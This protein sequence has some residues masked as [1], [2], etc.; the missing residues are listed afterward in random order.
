MKTTRGQVVFSLELITIPIL[1]LATVEFPNKIQVS[2]EPWEL[3]GQPRK[4][5][6]LFYT[7]ISGSPAAVVH[8]RFGT[9]AQSCGVTEQSFSHDFFFL[10]LPLVTGR[11]RKK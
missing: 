1:I 2:S 3:G 6:F 9:A 4:E 11:R 8:Q 10:F 5:T 7:S